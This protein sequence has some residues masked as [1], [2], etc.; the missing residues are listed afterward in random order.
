MRRLTLLLTLVLAAPA[1]ALS[2]S[3][4]HYRID[5]HPH[6]ESFAAE[7]TVTGK[8]HRYAPVEL[9]TRCEL[10]PCRVTTYANSKGK[11]TADFDV[12][13]PRGQRH[14]RLRAISGS[15]ET[16]RGYGIVL[17]PY[18]VAPPYSDD[19][20][21]PELVMTGDS[22]AIGTDYD[23]RADLPGW[24]VTSDGRIGRPL[25]VGMGVLGM[26]PLEAIPRVLAFSLFTNDDPRNIDALETAMRDSLLRLGSSDCAVW[27]TIVRPKVAGVT[28]NAVN[29]RMRSLAAEDERLRIV[30]WAKAIKRHPEWLSSDHVHPTATGYEHRARMYATAA[31]ACAADYG[32]GPAGTA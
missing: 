5:A 21:V 1:H 25:A 15:T 22:L 29:A 11:Y 26:T 6:A 17:P 9:R 13:I 2:I 14:L 10:G 19:A 3:A 23:L 4:P 28:Y 31:E 32:W 27:A 18:A 7:L 8:A 24:R 12:V 20:E 16:T 30:D